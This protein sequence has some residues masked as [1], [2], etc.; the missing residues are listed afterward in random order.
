MFRSFSENLGKHRETTPIIVQFGAEGDVPA[1][2]WQIED[3]FSENNHYMLTHIKSVREL[4]QTVSFPQKTETIPSFW[5]SL[6]PGYLAYRSPALS[7]P[8]FSCNLLQAME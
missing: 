1:G 6:P 7:F 5:F 8:I 2:S 3:M 4:T